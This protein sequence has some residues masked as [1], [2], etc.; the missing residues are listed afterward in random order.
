MNAYNRTNN[1]IKSYRLCCFHNGRGGTPI[2]VHCWPQPTGC[3]TCLSIDIVGDTVLGDLT[4]TIYC[5][6]NKLGRLSMDRHCLLQYPSRAIAGRNILCELFI[7]LH[8]SPQWV[9]HGVHRWPLPAGVSRE[10]YQIK[11]RCGRFWCSFSRLIFT[12]PDIVHTS[13]QFLALALN[14]P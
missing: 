9:V 1:S 14:C 4:A 10:G 13:L 8:R 2:H 6:N 7:D 11:V 3:G 5:G 12:I